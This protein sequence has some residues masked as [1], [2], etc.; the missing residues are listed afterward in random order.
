M[1]ENVMQ[2]F[3]HFVLCFFVFNLQQF[4]N[5]TEIV[6]TSDESN[7][8]IEGRIYVSSSK[9]KDWV[10]NTRVLVDGGKYRGFI[11]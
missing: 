2:Q 6:D 9:D 11:R 10:S 3:F 1:E 4:G 8:K 5:T 7:F